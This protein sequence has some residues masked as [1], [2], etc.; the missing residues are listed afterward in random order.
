MLKEAAEH[1]KK[2]TSLEKIYFILFD[3]TAL[4]AF[5]KELREMKTRGDLDGDSHSG[6]A[7]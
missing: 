4:T 3:K 7:Q 5:E 6:A 2:P 1:L